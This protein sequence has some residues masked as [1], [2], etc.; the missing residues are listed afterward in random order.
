MISA[1][2]SPSSG[3]TRQ[4]PL[5]VGLRRDDLQHRNDLAGAGQ[6]VGDEAVMGKLGQLFDANAG[7]AENFDGRPAPEGAFLLESEITPPT[8]DNI[9][10]VDPASGRGPAQ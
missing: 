6:F 10:D 5:D 3:A 9:G 4:Q 8:G 1:R 7:M 2:T